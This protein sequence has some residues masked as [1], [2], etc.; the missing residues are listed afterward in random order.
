MSVAGDVASAVME[1]GG[2]ALTAIG[3]VAAS[4]GSA[5][6]DAGAAVVEHAPAVLGAVV[7]AGEFVIDG[8]ANAL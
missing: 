8:V 7:A 5:I 6:V 1:H 3:E 2:A 4:A